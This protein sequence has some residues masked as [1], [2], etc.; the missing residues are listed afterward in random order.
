VPA[1]HGAVVNPQPRSASSFDGGGGNVGHRPRGLVRRPDLALPGGHPVRLE[2]VYARRC[3]VSGCML[4][5]FERPTARRSSHGVPAQAAS[6]M[7]GRRQR[8]L[9]RPLKT[10]Q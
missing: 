7:A 8:P 1:R 5:S 9:R 2:R 3:I 6:G 10:A 4:L